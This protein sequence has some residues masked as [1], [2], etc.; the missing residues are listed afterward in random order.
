MTNRQDGSLRVGM[1]GYSFMGV[2]HSQAWRNAPSF[3]DL[4]VDPVRAAICGRNVQ[5]A[6]DVARRFGWGSLENDWRELTRRSDIDLIDICTPGNTHA[7][8]AIAA[9]EAGKHVLCEKPMANS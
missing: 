9:L 2:A 1:V 3:F 5:A 4:P 7:E 8:I 6:A